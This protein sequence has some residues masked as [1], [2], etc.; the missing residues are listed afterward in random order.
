MNAVVRPA[1]AGPAGH[2]RRWWA[3]DQW[4]GI[5][6]VAPACLVVCAVLL[7]P[8]VYNVWV[9]LL[10][11]SWHAPPEERGAW[12]G[13]GNYAR[14]LDA[15]GFQDAWVNTARFVLV[16]I[17][18]EYAAGLGMALVMGARIVGRGVVRTSFL[19]PMMLAPVVVGIQWRWLLSGNFGVV[20]YALTRVGVNA[21]SW[22]SD[23]DY[24]MYMVILADVW[25]H[26]PFIALIL[27][28]ALQ[29][30][31]ADIYE[32]A[33]VDGASGFQLFR[34]I[35][36]PLIGAASLIAV[37]IRFGDLLKSFDLIYAMTGGGPAQTTQVASLYTFF[38]GFSQGELGQAAAVANIV[39]VVALVAGVVMVARIRTH[40]GVI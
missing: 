38:L 12:V 4:L 3:T 6:L 25:Q 33:R 9:S 8:V 15:P 16:S 5:L 26:A 10:S 39:A 40:A 37:V 22:L 29:S 36:F 1:R 2:G 31:P 19:V 23:P 18:L 20:H 35:T 13:L 30:I 7:Y 28:A 24:A 17:V 11:W 21:P 32:A 34:T 27:L 14:L